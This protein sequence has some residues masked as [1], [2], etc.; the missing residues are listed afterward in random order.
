MLLGVI[1]GALQIYFSWKA[2]PLLGRQCLVLDEQFEG[3]QL[4]TEGVWLR[5]ADMG[6]FGYVGPDFGS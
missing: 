6:G 3:D 5:E 4:D 2:V 1:A